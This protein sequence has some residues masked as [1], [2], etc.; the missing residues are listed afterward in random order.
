MLVSEQVREFELKVQREIS[1]K[2][3]ELLAK[4]SPGL[5]IQSNSTVAE[6][7]LLHR[8]RTCE[9]SKPVCRTPLWTR[10]LIQVTLSS[11]GT[12]KPRSSHQLLHRGKESRCLQSSMP[13]VSVDVGAGQVVAWYL[14]F[15]FRVRGIP[16]P[17]FIFAVNPQQSFGL[18]LF[19]SYP[20]FFSL[21]R[22]NAL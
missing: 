19:L 18:L 1:E 12:Q 2:R 11:L 6:D 22:R 8:R 20:S 16:P 7:V 3:Q 5:C 21:I 4:V 14:V 17:S 15:F 13:S 9:T 10:R